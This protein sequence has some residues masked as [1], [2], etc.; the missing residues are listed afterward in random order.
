MS[1]Y[2]CSTLEY[3]AHELF[4]LILRRRYSSIDNINMEAFHG[5]VAVC[6]LYVV[7]VTHIIYPHR[8]HM[9]DLKDITQDVH[10]E[11]FCTKNFCKEVEGEC[12]IEGDYYCGLLWLRLQR[13]C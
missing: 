13:R 7:Q 1:M 5:L 12:I 8:T 2:A 11:N 4:S 3:S 6:L 10:Y 9:Q